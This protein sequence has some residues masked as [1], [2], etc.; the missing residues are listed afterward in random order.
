MTSASS[1]MPIRVHQTFVGHGHVVEGQRP[2]TDVTYTLKSVDEICRDGGGVGGDAPPA[3]IEVPHVFGLVRTVRPG[4]L[5]EHVG[6]RLTLRLEDE[7]ALDF[8]VAKVLAPTSYLIQGL[9]LV[10]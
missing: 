10:V 7:R 8:T 3:S 2:L 5:V 9:G 4:V 6:A 1:S